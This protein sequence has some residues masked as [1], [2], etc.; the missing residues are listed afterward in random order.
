MTSPF[1]IPQPGL[2]V[3]PGSPSIDMPTQEEAAVYPA[4]AAKILE[5]IRAAQAAC[6]G[7]RLDWVR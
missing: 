4:E 7:F 1:A 5:Q 6:S 3:K 2:R